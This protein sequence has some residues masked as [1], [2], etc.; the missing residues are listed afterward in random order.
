MAQFCTKCGS[1]LAEGMKFCTGCGAT[2]GEPAAPAVQA[3]ATPAPAPPAPAPTPA[4]A[5]APAATKAGTAIFKIILG[6]FAV[7]LF[8]GLL[9]VGAGVFYYYHYV[10]PKVAQV[11]N[12]IRSFPL[13]GATREVHTQPVVPAPST[14][15]AT[16]PINLT[17]PDY[18]GATPVGDQVQQ[19]VGPQTVGFQQY[20]QYTT[21]DSVD[22]VVAFYKD[23]LGPKAEVSQMANIATLSLTGSN[24]S[25]IIS[26]MPDA[27][28]GKIKLAIGISQTP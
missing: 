21:S 19:P 24:G 14:A 27:D 9:C 4:A 18:P 22:K 3:N 6:V 23:K 28:S 8:L 16:S 12:T 15:D 2:A 7:L 25:I 17:V 20:R 5:P 13:P 10:K 26:I 1:P 11:E